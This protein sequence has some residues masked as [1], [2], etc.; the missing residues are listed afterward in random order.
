MMIVC[1][2]G[3]ISKE[4]LSRTL[5]DTRSFFKHFRE[6]RRRSSW[7]GVDVNWDDILG[8]GVKNLKVDKEI[9]TRR[10]K[11]LNRK[12]DIGWAPALLQKQWDNYFKQN[13]E[14]KFYTL[15]VK[16]FIQLEFYI[17]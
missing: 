6:K 12:W 4:N 11:R 15:I 3:R 7:R 9:K 5:L 2:Y 17:N 13:A 16:N 8:D 1:L 14:L 10:D